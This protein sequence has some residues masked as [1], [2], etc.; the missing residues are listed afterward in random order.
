MDQIPN[1]PY[2]QYYQP[3]QQLPKT[4]SKSIVAL[5]LGILAIVVPYLGFFIGIVSIVYASLSFKEIKRTGEQGRGLAIAGLVCGI[6]GT[7]FYAIFLLIAIIALIFIGSTG[8]DL[9]YS[10]I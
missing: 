7:A 4:N 6:I 8:T 5:V 10:S 9:N 3:M 1:E 2:N